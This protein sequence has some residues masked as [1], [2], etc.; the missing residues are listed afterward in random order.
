MQM[1]CFIKKKIAAK[2]KV[3]LFTVSGWRKKMEATILRP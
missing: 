3:P 2:K 1:K